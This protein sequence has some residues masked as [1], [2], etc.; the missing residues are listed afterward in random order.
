MESA[1]KLATRTPPWIPVGANELDHS[2]GGSLVLAAYASSPSTEVVSEVVPP[3][4]FRD[5]LRA[6]FLMSAN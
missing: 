1:P 5:E 4:M 2:A 3:A 6:T